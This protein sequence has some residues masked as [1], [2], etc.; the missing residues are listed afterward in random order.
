MKL[1]KLS[2]NHFKDEETKTTF[3]FSF[4]YELS[5]EEAERRAYALMRERMEYL[6]REHFFGRDHIIPQTGD[7]SDKPGFYPQS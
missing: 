5:T 7:V 6:L 3:F 2:A 1:V 4:N